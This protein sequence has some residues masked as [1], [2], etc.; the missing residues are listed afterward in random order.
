MSANKYDDL[1][2]TGVTAEQMKGRKYAT[3]GFF[4]FLML[5]FIR[6]VPV[7]SI[8]EMRTLVPS[9]DA[10]SEGKEE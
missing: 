7:L 3:L 9:G 10:P 2:I 1:F 8:F 6:Y 4:G 5:L